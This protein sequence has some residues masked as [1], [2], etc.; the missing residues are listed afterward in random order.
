MNKNEESSPEF[1]AQQY[2]QYWEM[3]RFHLSLSWQIPALAAA[4]IIGF[5]T[6]DPSNLRDWNEHPIVP[7]V[8]FVFM[9][10]FVGV[11]RIHHKRNIVLANN[12]EKALVELEEAHGVPFRVHH[13]QLQ[14]QKAGLRGLSSSTALDIFLALLAVVLIGAAVY[15]A[16]GMPTSSE[17]ARPGNESAVNE[18]LSGAL[19]G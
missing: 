7:A 12:F 5:V 9:G 11:M 3:K 15:F 4:A 17:D 2:A 10:L 13:N 18:S 19:Y 8:A 16:T 1:V 6:I 14:K